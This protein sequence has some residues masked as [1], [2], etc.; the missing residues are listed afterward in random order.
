M[1]IENA[2]ASN[3]IREMIY[4]MFLGGDKSVPIDSDTQLIESGICDSMSLVGLAAELESRFSGIS[5]QDQDITH[6][7]FASIETILSFLRNQ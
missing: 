3:I 4:E 2:E 6:E 7:N 5:I 1:N